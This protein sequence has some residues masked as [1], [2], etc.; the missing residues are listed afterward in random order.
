M[1]S[2]YTEEAQVTVNDRETFG[3]LAVELQII[4]HRVK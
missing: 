1:E 2:V 3:I 4:I